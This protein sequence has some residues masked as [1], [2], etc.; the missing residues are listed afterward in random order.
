MTC[1]YY[2]VALSPLFWQVPVHVMCWTYFQKVASEWVFFLAASSWCVFLCGNKP[3][4]SHA[5]IAHF[6]LL[7][8]RNTIIYKGIKNGNI[9]LSTLMTLRQSLIVLLLFSS[10]GI[11]DIFAGF[12]CGIMPDRGIQCGFTSG[13]ISALSIMV[14]HTRT[15]SQQ[16]VVECLFES[17]TKCDHVWFCAITQWSTPVSRELVIRSPLPHGLS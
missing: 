12:S 5:Q 8:C 9:Q 15:A 4:F 10:V 1:Y 16:E 13:L 3:Q 7:L 11:L 17:L 2:M 14:A 6:I